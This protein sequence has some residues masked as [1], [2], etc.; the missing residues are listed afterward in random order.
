MTIEE[1]ASSIEESS[2]KENNESSLS[3]HSSFDKDE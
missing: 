2:V 1:V 3:S